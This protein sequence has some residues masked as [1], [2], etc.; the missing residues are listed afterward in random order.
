MHAFETTYG[1]VPVYG[2]EVYDATNLLIEALGRAGPPS[3][4]QIL[5]I[6][7]ETQGF[8]GTSGRIQ[9]EPNGDRHNPQVT[10]W[11]VIQGKMVLVGLARD[12]IPDRERQS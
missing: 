10:I 7:Q 1:P 11:Q 3:R 4:P 5:Q 8:E 6:V 2:A 12:L 9:F